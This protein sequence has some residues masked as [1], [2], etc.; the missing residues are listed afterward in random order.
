MQYFFFLFSAVFIVNESEW[1]TVNYVLLVISALLLTGGPSWVLGLYLKRELY[2][3]IVK[4]RK[5]N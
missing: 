2:P 3:R 1:T 5:D 4:Y